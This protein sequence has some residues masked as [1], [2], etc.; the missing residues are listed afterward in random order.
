MKKIISN[1]RRTIFVCVWRMVVA[2]IITL[3]IIRGCGIHITKGLLQLGQVEPMIGLMVLLY[4]FQVMI[5]GMG[6][7]PGLEPPTSYFE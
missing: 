5:L 7:Q 3:V 2:V 1:N 4:M 6:Y